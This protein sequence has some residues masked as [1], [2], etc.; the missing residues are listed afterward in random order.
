MIRTISLLTLTG[1]ALAIFAG[2]ADAAVAPSRV[3]V[4]TKREK[5]LLRVRRLLQQQQ[6]RR[7]LAKLGMNREEIEGRLEMLGDYELEMLADRLDSIAVGR[8]AVGIVVVVLVIAALVLLI[9]WL[10]QRV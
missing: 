7:R 8:S 9:V 6:V 2:S 3:R 1:L 10:A 5:N 4:E